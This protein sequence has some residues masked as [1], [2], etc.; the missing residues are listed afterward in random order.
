MTLQ[1]V[2]VFGGTGFLGRL[3]V[4][5][6]ARHGV[7]VRAACRHP[8]DQSAIELRTSGNLG[9]VAPI[10][11]DVRDADSVR[12]AVEN[13]DAVVNCVGF[14]VEGGR[15]AKFSD[16]HVEG[17]R[18][19]ARAA[20]EAGAQG[21][22]HLSGIGVDENARNAYVRARAKGETAVRE[23]F[24]GATILRPSV[25][26]GP[27][28]SFFET[29]AAV[30]RFSPALPLYGGGDSRIQPV[31]VAD[32]ADAAFAA[33]TREDAAGETYEL[34]GPKVYTVRQAFE[35]LL[36]EVGR[37]RL[38][39]PVPLWAGRL[40]AR[41]L[42]LLPNPPLTVDQID[43]MAADNVVAKDA[44]TLADLD[45]DAHAAE[46]ILPTY[47]DRFRRGGRYGRLRPA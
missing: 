10:W 30:A 19:V 38:L 26:F 11:A 25:M 12:A 35:L 2:T 27:G 1:R 36:Y 46:A 23:A 20:A 28:D 31:Y 17:A 40:Q 14:W 42:S 18:T 41:L 15:G 32:V 33:L 22:V 4:H 7:V 6:L 43:L 5:R 47:L 39:L 21:L 44:R 9:Q 29:L 13:V 8:R 37:R 16:V 24:P 45:V 34:G 3:V